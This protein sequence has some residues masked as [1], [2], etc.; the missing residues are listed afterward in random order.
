MCCWVISPFCNFCS[1]RCVI[2]RWLVSKPQFFHL[3]LQFYYISVAVTLF[4][5]RSTWYGVRGLHNFWGAPI[6]QAATAV[7]ST[8]VL[9]AI[10]Y[11]SHCEKS[12]YYR[13][14]REDGLYGSTSCCISQCL[15]H[16]SVKFDADIFV[17]SGVID[18]FF[19][20]L[21]IQDGGGRHLGFSGYVNLVFP[22]CW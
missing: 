6:A 7:F 13:T 19:T 9:T 18:I 10:Y 5:V 12:L 22:A 16:Y 15:A 11:R 21:K 2:R 4:T 20:Y 14:S 8:K 1:F 3:Y 17:Q